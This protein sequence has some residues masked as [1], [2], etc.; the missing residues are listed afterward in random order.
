MSKRVLDRDLCKTIFY[1]HISF[2][3]GFQPKFYQP[4]FYPYLSFKHS[5]W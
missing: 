3:C 5:E 2:F 1:F 4:W